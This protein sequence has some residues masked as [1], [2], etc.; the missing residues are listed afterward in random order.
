MRVTPLSSSEIAGFRAETPGCA[1]VMHF[2]HAGASLMPQPVL[3]ATIGHLQLEAE[4]GGYEAAD[5]ADE[6]L[7]A[8]Y[9]SVASL[10]GAR[11]AE[12]AIVENATRAWDM[13]FYA[14]PFAPGDRI[15][16]SV[17]EYASNV[18]AF[19]QVAQRGVS[20]EVVPND[21][22]GQ[23]SVSALA[24]LLDDRVRVVAVSHMPT[25]GGLVQPAAEIGRL[26]RQSGA[27]FLLDAC[28]TVGQMPIDVAA[29][30]CDILSA[31]SR[32]YLRGPRGVGFLYVRDEL[33]E[34]LTPPF[35]DLHAARWTA[36]SSYEIRNDARRFENWES[37]V[38]G[39]LGMGAAADYA[40]SIGLDRIWE[41]VHR[42]AGSLR[43]QLGAIPGVSVHDQ[44]VVQGGICTF[45]HEG[46][47]ADEVKARLATK[48]INTTASSVFS[49]R[50]DMES[51][52]LTKINRASVHYFTTDEEIAALVETVATLGESTAGI[53]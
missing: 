44:G 11:P 45:S 33:I 42:N 20:V 13:A 22:H 9:D 1:N 49:T 17:A 25:N 34:Q 2:N 7:E 31:T 18:I 43:E 29:L 6:R 4:I 39:R 3:D 5:R 40:L 50:F 36:P 24:N 37:F 15:L 35:L 26:A 47:T 10:I 51:R 28:Q 38:A 53:P 48:R 46:L 41:T 16:T 19:L 30:N 8:V 27:L 12:I 14:I 23:L 52:G 21:E 32:K